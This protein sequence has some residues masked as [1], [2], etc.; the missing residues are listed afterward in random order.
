MDDHNTYTD[1]TVTSYSIPSQ[2]LT[3]ATEQPY[4]ARHVVPI[5]QPPTLW[6]RI[7]QRFKELMCAILRH[8]CVLDVTIRQ[9][10]EGGLQ[11]WRIRCVSCGAINPFKRG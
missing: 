10:H 5:P 3:S 8:K 7:V 2:T 6:Q 9:E 11:P 4:V 1:C